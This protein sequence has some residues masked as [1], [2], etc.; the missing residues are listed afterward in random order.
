MAAALQGFNSPADRSIAVVI[1]QWLAGEVLALLAMN[2]VAMNEPNKLPGLVARDA[3]NPEKAAL[4]QERFAMDA[5][6]EQ[7]GNEECA[8]P[9][10]ETQRPFL[11]CVDDHQGYTEGQADHELEGLLIVW[12]QIPAPK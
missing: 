1:R 5:L 8:D 11:V 12:L 4:R 7:A 10:A 3:V 2:R 6:S 9:Q